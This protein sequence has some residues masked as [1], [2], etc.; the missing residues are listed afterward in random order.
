MP[1]SAETGNLQVLKSRF[2]RYWY[3]LPPVYFQWSSK[4]QRSPAPVRICKCRD[5]VKGEQKLESD[6]SEDLSEMAGG[7]AEEVNTE[8][9][10]MSSLVIFLGLFIIMDC[11]SAQPCKITVLLFEIKGNDHDH[12]GSV[13]IDFPPQGLTVKE[14]VE[15]IVKDKLKDIKYTIPENAKY[16][17]CEKNVLVM[18]ADTKKPNSKFE[19]AEFFTVE[20]DQ[21]PQLQSKLYIYEGTQKFTPDATKE[22]SYVLNLHIHH[23]F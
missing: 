18:H 5:H 1:S 11:I 15:A 12:I 9:L 23:Y 10:T 21:K 14:A 22:H 17:H 19:H 13:D 7:V 8:K 2:F 16:G 3:P 6:E 20:K 4:Q